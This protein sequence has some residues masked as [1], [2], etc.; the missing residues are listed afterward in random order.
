MAMFS[1]V[2]AN[3]G[4]HGFDR[5]VN[6]AGRLHRLGRCAL[7]KS[8]SSFNFKVKFE[9]NFKSVSPRASRL[10]ATYFSQSPEK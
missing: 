5:G 6:Q 1:F 10:Q 7:L 4:L 2:G 8:I 3:V 9:V